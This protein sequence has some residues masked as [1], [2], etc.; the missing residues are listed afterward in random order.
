MADHH[1]GRAGA[2]GPAKRVVFDL[3][4]PGGPG[5]AEVVV[6]HEGG[7]ELARLEASPAGFHRHELE[8]PPSG[9]DR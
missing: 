6:S 1:L 4:R 3:G 2:A 8:L 9:R 5:P 7:A